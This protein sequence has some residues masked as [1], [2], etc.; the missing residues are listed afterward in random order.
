MRGWDAYH[1]YDFRGALAAFKRVAE[2]D[3]QKPI[4]VG[5]SFIR[6]GRMLP[7]QTIQQLA[8][9][10][11]RWHECAA[12]FKYQG[13]D[14]LS[15]IWFSQDIKVFDP[16]ENGVS[17]GSVYISAYLLFFMSLD[18]LEDAL[19]DFSDIARKIYMK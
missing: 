7:T 18:T 6:Y 3:R 4:H 16:L 19:N 5:I 15:I 2:I 10:A 17:G 12:N 14:A 13:Q 8:D 9:V 1:A 11:A